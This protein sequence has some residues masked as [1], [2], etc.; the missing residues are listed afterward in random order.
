MPRAS[1]QLHPPR[2]SA[3]LGRSL[4]AWGADVSLLCA[5]QSSQPRVR[6]D[7]MLDD[8]VVSHADVWRHSLTQAWVRMNLFPVAQRPSM[9]YM[10]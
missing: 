1:V 5:W 3:G 9:R 4:I 7:D 8:F 2:V 10:L 6:D